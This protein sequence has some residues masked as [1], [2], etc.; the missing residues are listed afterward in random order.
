[1]VQVEAVRSDDAEE[2]HER[3]RELYLQKLKLKKAR[4]TI[5]K[6]A[7]DAKNLEDAEWLGGVSSI[8]PLVWLRAP[9]CVW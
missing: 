8:F 9:L 4:A 1:M 7:Q 6:I 3:E 2:V 5:A